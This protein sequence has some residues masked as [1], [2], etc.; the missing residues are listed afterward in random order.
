MMRMLLAALELA[1]VLAGET[2]GCGVE[3]KIAAAHVFA[4]RQEA[5][6]VGGWFGDGEPTALDV[7]VALRWQEWP[8]P[9]D[10]ALFFL[11][12]GDGERMPWLVRRTGRWVCPGT[13]VESWQ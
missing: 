8:D 11:G 13:W 5:G 3:A 7:M 10:G 1:R 2:P 6:I 12:P 9:T 4:N